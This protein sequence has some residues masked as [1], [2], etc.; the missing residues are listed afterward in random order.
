MK[1]E[2]LISSIALT[3][4]PGIGAAGARNL[5]KAL[6]SASDV[7]KNRKNLRD[8]LPDVKPQLIELLDCS[9]AF[10]IAEKEY[11]FIQSKNISCLGYKDED[12]PSRLRECDDA[13]LYL[14]YKGHANLNSLRIIGVVGTRHITEYGKDLCLR[15]VNDLKELCPHTIIVSGLAYGVDIHAHQA[16]LQ[17]GMETIGVL[18]HGLD[19]IY[20][21]VHRNS[22]AKMIDQGGLLTEFISGTNPD[23]QNFVSRN[24]IVA[25]MCDA[26]I[27]VESAKKG[28]ALITAELAESY[29]RDCFA[30]PG[31]TNDPYSEGCNNLIRENKAILIN[32]AEDFVKSMCWETNTKARPKEIQRDLFPDLTTDEQILV[33]L[34]LKN[35][36]GMQINTMIVE[37]NI[38][39]QKINV[40]LFELEMKGIVRALAGGL[41]KLVQ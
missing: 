30:F 14:F 36:N 32:N 3:H 25:G 7:F 15:F 6:G 21:S 20:P 2:E 29:H 28:G 26:T 41:F 12:Y 13:P 19:R 10:T 16:A 11:H 18:A 31:R 1:E 40:L 38:A 9:Q 4:I 17:N 39:I 33:D 8:I 34:L 27:V 24:R 22:A 37:S 35:P 23:K 5:Y